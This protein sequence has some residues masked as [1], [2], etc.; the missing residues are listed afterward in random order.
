MAG[1]KTIYILNQD[2]AL[3]LYDLTIF[4]VFT[5]IFYTCY[6]S[7]QIHINY[8]QLLQLKPQLLL[9]NKD[10]YVITKV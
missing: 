9:T 6:Y 2:N 8:S 4:Q 1:K 3:L 10:S 7:K 5:S